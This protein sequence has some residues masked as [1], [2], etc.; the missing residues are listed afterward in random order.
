MQISKKRVLSRKSELKEY[1]G[2]VLRSDPPILAGVFCSRRHRCWNEMDRKLRVCVVSVRKQVLAG[3]GLGAAGAS[4]RGRP[5]SGTGCDPPWVSCPQ[6]EKALPSLLGE[7]P[8]TFS[9]S[10]PISQSLFR[11]QPAGL[12]PVAKSIIYSL[13]SGSS[14]LRHSSLACRPHLSPRGGASSSA[15]RSGSGGDR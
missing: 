12:G 4:N 1:W 5:A 6:V 11:Q 10:P 3:T 8:P 7:P 2:Q 9:P 13:H 15:P 14:S